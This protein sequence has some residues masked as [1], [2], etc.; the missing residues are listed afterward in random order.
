MEKQKTLFASKNMRIIARKTLY[1]RGVV[2]SHDYLG[3]EDT[4]DEDDY[5]FIL[6]TNG[7]LKGIWVPQGAEDEDIPD[8]IVNLIQEKWGIDV[9]K[10][11]AYGYLH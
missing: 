4:I 5:G 10:E 1:I 9:N 2:M 3:F 8:A 11:E 6:D 7:N